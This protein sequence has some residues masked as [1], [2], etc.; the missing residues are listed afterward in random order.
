METGPEPFILGNLPRADYSYPSSKLLQ[1]VRPCRSEAVSGTFAHELK[2]AAVM[3]RGTPEQVLKSI[4]DGINT[5]NLD[6]HMT[7]YESDAAF[8]SQPGSLAH[9]VPG[10]RESLAAF[11]AMKGTLDLKVTR[12]PEAGGLALV[13]GAW[14]F[15]GTGPDGAAVTLTGHNADVLRRQADGS[16]RFVIDNPWGT[17]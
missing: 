15:T 4:V 5:G 17:D 14:S 8:A 10:V 2:K 13:A 6:A 11:I 3:S 12:V 7:L 16:W 1:I 9:G